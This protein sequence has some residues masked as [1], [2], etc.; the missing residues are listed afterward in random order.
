MKQT[1]LFM[2]F[3]LIVILSSCKPDYI[4]TTPETSFTYYNF[5]Q[6][7]A[8]VDQAVVG[9][10][11]QVF[12]IYS[13]YMWVFGDMLSDNTS[14]KFNPNDR[15]GIEFEKLDEFLANSSEGTLANMY[16]ESYEGVERSNLVLESVPKVSFGSNTT[17]DV[18]IGEA[19]FFRAF[20]YFNLVRLYGEVPLITNII[21]NPDPNVVKN[22]PRKPVA[23][24]YS[25]VIIPDVLD[26]I[27]KLPTTVTAAERG[28]LTKA[29][30]NVLLAKVY[31]TLGRFSDALPVLAN[32]TGYTLNMGATGYK[33][34]FDPKKKNGPESI[35]E[36]QVFPGSYTFGFTPT[37][38]PWGTSNTI[39][40]N[41][42]NPRG[43]A[44]QPTTDLINSYETGDVRRNVTVAGT[45]P[46]IYMNKFFYPDTPSKTN[47]TQWPVYR[48]ADVLLMRAECLNE[49]G[50][51][52][53]TAFAD[54]N[55]VRTRA[56]LP[57]KTLGNTTPALAVNDQAAF[58]LA[59]E[60]E[61]RV[62]FAGEAHRWF[63][64]V[65]TGRV[66]T[67]MAAH[68][69]QERTLKGAAPQSMSATAYTDIKLLLA[70]PFREV[71]QFG[72]SQNTG[73]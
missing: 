61:R 26:A 3:C 2:A 39:W 59:I 5:P 57:N 51:N 27:A 68:G 69:V 70:I 50:F 16:R 22:Y 33:D 48:Y 55:A 34:N 21:I 11:K 8:Q 41:G 72:Y 13:S 31:M 1:K 9:C 14:F 46:N 65:R 64:L 24:A 66:T 36:I 44:N 30:A 10:Y 53:G 25:S 43:G 38:T 52:T 29:A 6:T 42:S 37:W 19:K 7:E 56:G 71:Q 67:V 35:Y 58:R 20:N 4:N 49:A 17:R 12:S 15:G 32:I 40:L 54:L 73:W 18:K 47:A 45:A 62:E 63:D 60:Q 28:K 23:E